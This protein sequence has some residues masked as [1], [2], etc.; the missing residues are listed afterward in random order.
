MRLTEQIDALEV[1]GVS[2]V[3]AL[4]APRV[5]ACILALPLLTVVMDYLALVG[6][7][8]AEYVT[9]GVTWLQYQTACLAG[10][11]FQDTLLATLKTVA[12]GYLIGVA[13]CYFGM[14][15]SGGTEGVGRAA[16]RGV[17]LATLSV[18]IANVA[19]VRL[20][21]LLVGG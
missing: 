16:T 10:L 14:T 9:S 8:A 6:S 12:F 15:A 2:A 18:L 21:Q 5:L 20:I 3:R 4:V 7:F 11:R 17:V 19:L 1:L 13:G